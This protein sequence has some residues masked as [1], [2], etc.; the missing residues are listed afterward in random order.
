MINYT[1][2]P[3]TIVWIF[4]NEEVNLFRDLLNISEDFEITDV[5]FGLSNK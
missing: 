2:L 3:P 1:M 5:I 4:W